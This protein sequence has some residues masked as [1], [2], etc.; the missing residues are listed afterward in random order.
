MRKGFCIAIMSL[1]LA[2]QCLLGTALPAFA[3][4]ARVTTSAFQSVLTTSIYRG[5]GWHHSPA[6]WWHFHH[7]GSAGLEINQYH[8]GD[9]DHDI[10]VVTYGGHGQE[11]SGNTSDNRG[12][13]QDNSSNGGN[14]LIVS[15]RLSEY[16][17]INQYSVGHSNYRNSFTHWG[18]YDQHNSGNSGHNIGLNQ[19]NS[20]NGGNQ[21]IG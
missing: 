8:Q 5:R 17:R 14:Q 12:H 16:R 13:N 19:D 11:D 9:S 6:R 21:I 2:G 10:P 3:A 20:E 7:W 15:P 18:G 1:L 4:P